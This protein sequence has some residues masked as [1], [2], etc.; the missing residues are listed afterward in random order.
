[1]IFANATKPITTVAL[2][3]TVSLM[4]TNPEAEALT[5]AK[6]HEAVANKA[7]A[8]P[9][10]GANLINKISF[11]QNNIQIAEISI[12][13][14]RWGSLVPA[15]QVMGSSNDIAIISNNSRKITNNTSGMAETVILLMIS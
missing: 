2:S 9:E 10:A 14:E 5:R 15:I 3:K 8:N 13:F 12:I 4:A 1:M 11:Q 6:I 7:I